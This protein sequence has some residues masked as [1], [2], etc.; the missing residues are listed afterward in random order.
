MKLI[1]WSLLPTWKNCWTCGAALK[2]A[3]PAWFA[4]ILQVPEDAKLTSPPLIEQTL[5]LEASMVKVTV[6]PELAFAVG[7]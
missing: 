1:V 4:L 7:V 3:S 5:P 6:R 2:F